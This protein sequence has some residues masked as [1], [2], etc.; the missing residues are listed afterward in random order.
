MKAV[1]KIFSGAFLVLLL[2]LSCNKDNS[3]IPY[4]PVN[5]QINLQNPDYFPLKTVGGWVYITGGSK[6]IIV[7]RADVDN[8]NA[9]DRHCTYK[10]EESCSKVDVDNGTLTALDTCCSSKFQLFDGSVLKSPATRSLQQ[11]QTSYDGNILSIN[12]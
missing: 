7:Y 2:T 10:P 5:I 1:Y 12:N 4:V 3:Y 11:Y 6:G 8:F 9:Y